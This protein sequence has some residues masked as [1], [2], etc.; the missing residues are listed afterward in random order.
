M[1]KL[2]L[3]GAVLAVILSAATIHAA[4]YLPKN[5]ESGGN[6]VISGTETLRNLYVAG[7]TVLSNKEVLGDL[8]AAGGSLNIASPV[9]EDV[10]LAGGNISISG[11]VG[12]DARVAG[13]NISLAAPIA[14]DLLVGGGTVTIAEAAKVG[15]DFWAAGG[16][17][18]L[19]A[20][21]AGDAK[22]CADE[23]F[24]NSTI[25][26]P[27][28]VRTG[29]KLTFGPEARVLGKIVHYGKNEAVIMEGAQVGA[30][31]FKEWDGAK[32]GVHGRFIFWGVAIVWKLLAMLVAALLFLKLFRTRTTAVVVTARERIWFNLGMGLAG[33]I[34]FPIVT[35]LLFF[36]IIG[37]Y[38]GF[39]FGVLFLSFS[40]VAGV[41]M[42]IFLGSLLEKLL[43]KE[44]MPLTWRTVL[45]G[46]LAAAI[47]SFIPVLGWALLLALYF[48]S[49][50]ALLRSS[51]G[52][53]EV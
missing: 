31:E 42:I 37:A 12:G 45:W 3:W 20:D 5:R 1:K 19:N 4:E 33:V 32:S 52:R 15:G 11:A 38:V 2:F 35:V 26:G 50:G 47:L 18:N 9:E 22:I 24:I 41:V 43:K 13:G 34:L 46:V 6:V 44:Y 14:G 10:T 53:M 25:T 27:L 17:I 30:I 40:L 8:F 29:K 48:I 23:I 28:E 16:I 21:V 36:T 49:F 7:A 39:L 51:R